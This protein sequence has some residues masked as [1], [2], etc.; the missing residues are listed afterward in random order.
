M[1]LLLEYEKQQGHVKVNLPPLLVVVVPMAVAVLLVLVLLHQAAEE[2]C[3]WGKQHMCKPSS[4]IEG[5]VGNWGQSWGRSSFWSSRS[6]WSRKGW[7]CWSMRSIPDVGA[8]GAGAAAGGGGQASVHM[9]WLLLLVRMAGGGGGREGR[10]LGGEGVGAHRRCRKR[11][12][13][14]CGAR[15]GMRDEG[16]EGRGREAGEVRALSILL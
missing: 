2:G 7:R 12:E 11:R 14:V 9:M 6:V 8:G 13:G 16:K 4:S 3:G 10:V 5:G 1:L 15:G